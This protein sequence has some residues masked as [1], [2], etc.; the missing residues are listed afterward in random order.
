MRARTIVLLPLFLLAGA[1]PAARPAPPGGDDLERRI[2]AAVRDAMEAGALR[3]LTLAADLGARQAVSEGW[4]EASSA[5]AAFRAGAL[6][7]TFVAIALLQ[8]VDEEKLAL[9]APVAG[10]LDAVELDGAVLVRHLLTHTSGLPSYADFVHGRSR[11]GGAATVG[12]VLAWLAES[13]PDADPG[14]CCEHSDTNVLLS[15]RIL[16]RVDGRP[17][18]ESLVARVFEPAGMQDTDYRDEPPRLVGDERSVREIRGGL[19]SAP[20]APAFFREDELCSTAPDIVRFLRAL[21]YG[22]LLKAGTRELLAEERFLADGSPVPLVPGFE[23]VE[24]DDVNGRAAGGALAGGRVHVAWYADV[25][26]AIAIL[27]DAPEARLDLLERRVARL[28][29]GLREPGVVDEPIS[30]GERRRFEGGYYVGCSE[31]RVE[32]DG[33]RLVVHPPTGAP[34]RLLFQGGLRFVSAADRET[35]IEFLAV[36]GRIDGFYLSERGA[37]VEGRRM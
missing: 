24:L 16:E 18:P 3:G 32:D 5:A 22:D 20:D 28:I 2:D 21:A 7:E 31:Y 23:L 1:L 36:D 10:V 33:E 30:A 11:A 29:L 14:A 9:D 15:G 34:Y 26:L 17:V 12:D 37:R 27:A 35:E 4:G 19:A 6:H 13:P 8:L 25:D